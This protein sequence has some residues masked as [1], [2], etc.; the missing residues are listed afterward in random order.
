M[1]FKFDLATTKKMDFWSRKAGGAAQASAQVQTIVWNILK[2]KNNVK[3]L[4]V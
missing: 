4:C 1:P 2:I 3:I